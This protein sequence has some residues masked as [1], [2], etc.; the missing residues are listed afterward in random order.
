MF[1]MRNNKLAEPPEVPVNDEYND[2]DFSSNKGIHQPS[3]LYSSLT[4]T[5]GGSASLLFLILFNSLYIV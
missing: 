4:G 2:E 3:S 5:S 1:W